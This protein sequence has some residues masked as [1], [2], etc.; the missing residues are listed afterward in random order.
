MKLS[1]RDILIRNNCLKPLAVLFPNCLIV[2][3]LDYT[4][5]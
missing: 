5:C 4:N 3:K 2:D 1:Y